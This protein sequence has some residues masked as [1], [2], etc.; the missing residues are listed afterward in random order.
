MPRVITPSDVTLARFAVTAYDDAPIL[1]PGFAAAPLALDPGLYQDGLYRFDNGAALAATGLLDGQQTL[2][3]AFRGTD[4]A[5]DSVA[6]LTGVNAEYADFASLV[7]AADAY[8]ATGAVEQVVATGHSLG[9]SYAQLH[10][11]THPDPADGSLAYRGQ[12]FGSPGAELEPAT[13]PRI[14]NVVI[15]DD[16]AVVL[17]THRGEV[18]G[19]LRADRDLAEAA[20][21]QAGDLFPGLTAEQ[22]LA[23]LPAIDAN[24]V[25][26]GTIALLPG[27]DASL[28]PASPR[29]LLEADPSRHEPDLYLAATEA[30]AAGTM[31]VRLVPTAPTTAEEAWYRAVYAGDYDNAAADAL[32]EAVLEGWADARDD[33]GTW[34]ADART[35]VRDGWQDAMNAVRGLDLF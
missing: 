18:G 22:A 17:G 19:V 34:L 15:A 1:P 7:A 35:A 20:A 10:L 25:N 21:G 5:A 3:L 24:Y 31:P 32:A 9:G 27:E 26:R 13:D 2:V 11:A 6:N 4:D 14:E 28:D 29:G 16:P 33:A 8:V 12:T 23:A 30:A